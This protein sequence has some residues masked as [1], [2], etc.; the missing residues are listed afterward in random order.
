MNADEFAVKTQ[1]LVKAFAGQEVIKGC[2]MN[3]RKGSIYGFLGANGAGKTT[4][5][6]ILTG[7]L[8]PTA[9]NAEVLGMDVVER[10]DEILKNIG[11]MIEVPI[12]Y[13]HL[14]GAENLGIHLAYMGVQGMPVS[15]VLEL[16][17]LEPANKQPVSRYSLGMRQRLGIARAVI[18][19][20]KLLILNEPINGLDP[21][22]I[23]EMRELFLRM[24]Q[25]KNMTILISSHILSE[26][27]HTA[28]TVGVIVNGSIVEEIELSAVNERYPTGLEDYFFN[29][30]SGGK[31]NA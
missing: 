2:N 5:F 30:M 9:G 15:D 29:M 6:K 28:D 19:N 18:H 27:E 25:E 7:L 20:P 23:K 12:F 31:Q 4:M 13:D 8:L 17:G 22:G 11:S 26:V 24:V 10:R 3:V 21:M 16:V 1:K 14:T